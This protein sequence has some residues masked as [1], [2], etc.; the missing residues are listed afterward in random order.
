MLT[1]HRRRQSG[2]DA[3]HGGRHADA[4]RQ[5]LR[6]LHADGGRRLD[7][8]AR[9]QQSRGAGAQCRRHADRHVHGATRSDGTAQ[10]VTITIN[11]ANDAAVIT[12]TTTGTVIG[13][14]RRQ[15]RHAGHADRDRRPDSTPTSTIRRTRSRRSS[16]RHA[17]DQRLRQLRDD[18][19]RRSGPTRSTTA[20]RRCRRSMSAAR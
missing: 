11:G 18:C 14:R 3:C 7:L 15:Q 16:A 17:S 13:S 6:H 5:R 2:N 1:R 4:Q 9:Q 19:G 8:H 10:V 12:G 20:T